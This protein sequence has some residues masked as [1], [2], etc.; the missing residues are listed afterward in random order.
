MA[1]ADLTSLAAEAEKTERIP[2]GLLPSLPFEGVD[3]ITPDP[4]CATEDEDNRASMHPDRFILE[5]RQILLDTLSM[6]F[7]MPKGSRHTCRR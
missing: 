2:D 3:L 5:P 4:R 1:E 7:L 6:P